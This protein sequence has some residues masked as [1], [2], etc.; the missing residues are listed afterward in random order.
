MFIIK[1]RKSSL[2]LTDLLIVLTGKFTMISI[3]TAGFL[4]L[5]VTFSTYILY[6][7]MYH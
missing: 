1:Q 3:Q 5:T 6:N 7:V 4:R 2:C